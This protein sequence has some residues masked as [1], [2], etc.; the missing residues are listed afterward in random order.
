MGE[1]VPKASAEFQ[2]ITRRGL[3]RIVMYQSNC[4]KFKDIPRN[5]SGG[6][7]SRTVSLDLN[8]FLSFCCKKLRILSNKFLIFLILGDFEQILS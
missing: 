7:G 3:D 4:L 2:E 1:G 6:G 5:L 8:R